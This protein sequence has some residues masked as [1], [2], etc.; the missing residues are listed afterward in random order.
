[1]DDH[2]NNP[3]LLPAYSTQSPHPEP[4]YC[5]LSN[6]LYP[7]SQHLT[8]PFPNH[9]YPQ[10]EHRMDTASL[11][12][13]SLFGF[14]LLSVVL[15]FVGLQVYRN[16]NTPYAHPY[17]PSSHTLPP[18]DASHQYHSQPYPPSCLPCMSN[19]DLHLWSDDDADLSP[20]ATAFA[21]GKKRDLLQVDS[22]VGLDAENRAPAQRPCPCPCPLAQKGAASTVVAGKKKAPAPTD[23]DPEPPAPKHSRITKATPARVKAEK[24]DRFDRPNRPDKPSKPRKGP[25][26]SGRKKGLSFTI[27]RFKARLAIATK[28]PKE[29]TVSCLVSPR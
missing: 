7:G 9:P 19:H 25:G 3:P 14:S 28:R 4:P 2:A 10:D 5:A 23:N 24:P 12:P 16:P 27:G 15:Q 22:H 8:V 20:I 13:C 1:M 29:K 11:L 18:L 6:A 26:R 17:H 21:C